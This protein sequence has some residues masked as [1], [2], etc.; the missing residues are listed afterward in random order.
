MIE[1]ASDICKTSGSV[2]G[3]LVSLFDIVNI[4]P[5]HHHHHHFWF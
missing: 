4:P 1:V 5:D 2:I 3:V